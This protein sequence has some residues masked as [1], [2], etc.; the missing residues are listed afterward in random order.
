MVPKSPDC[1]IQEISMI[2]STTAEKRPKSENCQFSNPPEI[3]NA[4][5]SKISEILYSESFKNE[6]PKIQNTVK[7]G[8]N[9][10]ISKVG[11][12]A[13]FE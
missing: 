8:E 9:G 7:T 3:F 12:P 6:K 11:F 4:N 5:L 1:R 13:K 10:T 2:K